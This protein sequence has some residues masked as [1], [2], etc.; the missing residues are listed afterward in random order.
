MWFRFFVSVSVLDEKT[1]SQGMDD[2]WIGKKSMAI[3]KMVGKER[4]FA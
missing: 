1:L 3:L 2:A 4:S